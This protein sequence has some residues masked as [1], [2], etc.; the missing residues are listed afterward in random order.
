[1]STH[2]GNA[3]ADTSAAPTAA[4]NAPAAKNSERPAIQIQNLSYAYANRQVLNN[5]TTEF[6]FGAV[7]GVFGENGAGKTTLLK[8]LAGIL[9]FQHNSP[10]REN[11]HADEN[12]VILS[13][14][15][16]IRA[17]IG[18]LGQQ[19]Q[20]AWALKVRSLVELGTLSRPAWSKS[21]KHHAIENAMQ[22]TDCAHL[23]ER[24]VS[25]ISTGELQRALLARVLA[26]KPKVILADE[27]TAGL[28]PRHQRAVMQLLQAHAHAGGMVIVVMHDLRAGQE[29]CDNALL[30]ADNKVYAQGASANVLTTDNIF[31][32][33]G[34]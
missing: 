29:Y 5:I 34:V 11:K 1:M 9:P 2:F 33:F 10:Q 12:E 15:A 30:L 6:N 25:E 16:L 4:T 21:E 23:A 13:F 27:P 26:G 3:P 24:K 22:Q 20:P 7:T 28:D 8:I 32:V 18:Y 31:E 14:G 17:D 19:V